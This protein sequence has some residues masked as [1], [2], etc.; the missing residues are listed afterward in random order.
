[1]PPKRHGTSKPRKQGTK[2]PSD[3][4][5]SK[6]KK[7]GRSMDDMRKKRSGSP[8]RKKGSSTKEKIRSRS[9]GGAGKG[10][11]SKSRSTRGGGGTSKPIKKEP[12]RKKS[13][14]QKMMAKACGSTVT[15][16][17]TLEPSAQKHTDKIGLLPT[18]IKKLRY[19]FMQIDYD[20]SGEVDAD[21]FLE[22]V[23]ER[24]SPFTDHIFSHFDSDGSGEVDFNEF[25]GVCCT[26]CMMSKQELLRFT[27]DS[28]D[29]DK[30]GTLDEEE[31]MILCKAVN[32]MNPTFPGNFTTA[33]EEFDQN[34]DGLI[35]FDEFQD[36]NRH[37]PLVLFP[38]FRLQDRIQK[39]TLG[40]G[41]WVSVAKRCAK[42]K[43][44]L[45]YMRLHGGDPPPE[46]F[47]TR[48]GRCFKT[49]DEMRMA[50][51]ISEEED[52]RGSPGSPGSPK[53]RR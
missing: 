37:Y 52:N 11:S 18:E 29:I 24:R 50:M 46:S 39:V 33:L 35:D 45:E 40:E 25:I 34:G 10:G 23:D 20:E 30:G 7:N 14:F 15:L 16:D 53:G 36:L 48:L 28:F 49:T 4:E 26:Y 1:M 13:K 3:F 42:S 19:A 38:A 6:R 27:F 47:F 8:S 2:R 9:S 12:K 43:Y 22:F 17:F 32:N 44:I 21:E 31:F 41:G 5:K 51:K